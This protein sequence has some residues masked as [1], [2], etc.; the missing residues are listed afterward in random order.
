MSASSMFSMGL[1]LLKLVNTIMA[2]VE[3]KRHMTE[4]RRL[5]LAAEL[6]SIAQSAKVAKAMR[7]EVDKLSDEELIDEL[8]K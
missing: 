6:A 7:A 4:G 1:A 5:Q 8:T 3:R 2:W